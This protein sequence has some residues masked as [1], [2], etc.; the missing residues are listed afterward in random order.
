MN[1][2]IRIGSRKS[3]LALV[4]AN[5]VKN[6][7]DAIPGYS[8]V[9]ITM[10]T[11]G[12][13]ILDRSLP[14]IG[15][16]GL[17]TREL[18]EQLLAGQIDLAVHSLKD[19][20]TSVP[21]G[22]VIGAIT[23][24]EDARDVFLSTRYDSFHALP[25]NA[26]IATGSLRRRAQ[27]LR[28]RPD[29]T[30]EDLRGNVPTRIDKLSRE[31]YDG[32]I[33]AAAGLLRLGLEDSISAFF[34]VDEMIPAAGQGALGIETREDAT[35]LQPILERLH[36]TITARETSA[37][38]S[39]LHQLDGS[40]QVPIGVS[41]RIGDSKIRIAVFVANLD[42]SIFLIERREGAVSEIASLSTQVVASL[43]SQ[44]AADV[45]RALRISREERDRT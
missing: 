17:F 6:L 29:I 25:R 16:K 4:Q 37:E 8:S 18:E 5:L 20:P 21:S 35:D 23:R 45:I 34:D 44:G 40:C 10:D 39:I 33:L 24:R 30:I 12:D 43:L 2:A 27:L 32:I 3:R 36:D 9:I 11:K 38:R 1:K 22:L 26:R 15:D 13:M 14:A 7:I 31:N 28:M 41:V 19:L 42:G